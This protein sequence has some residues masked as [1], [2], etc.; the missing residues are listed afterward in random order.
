LINTFLHDE[1]VPGANVT[2]TDPSNSVLMSG[3]PIVN[4]WLY[5]VTQRPEEHP[6]DGRLR[7]ELDYALSFFGDDARL[8]PQRL[9]GCVSL[10]AP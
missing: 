1:P 2:F 8:D 7:P 5:R 3:A 4:V 10:T 6:G 9:L